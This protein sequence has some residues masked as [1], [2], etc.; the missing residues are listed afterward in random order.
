MLQRQSEAL[1]TGPTCYISL[2]HIHNLYI[3]RRPQYI[4]SQAALV[5]ENGGRW[6]HAQ[7]GLACLLSIHLCPH[8]AHKVTWDHKINELASAKSWEVLPSIGLWALRGQGG[9][10]EQRTLEP[11]YGITSLGVVLEGTRPGGRGGMLHWSGGGGRHSRPGWAAV[12]CCLGSVP[13]EQE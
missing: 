8:L 7:E 10:L 2:H 1:N 11:V 13:G 6:S 12:M 9:S 3:K 5:R 4:Y